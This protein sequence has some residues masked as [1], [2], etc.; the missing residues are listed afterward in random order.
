MYYWRIT[1]YDPSLRDFQGKFLGNEWTS[2]SDI[3]NFYGDKQLILKDYLTVENAYIN[4]VIRFM[5]CSKISS[6][7]IVE[8]EKFD[9]KTIYEDNYSRK[10]IIS[11]ND[12]R[13][14][15]F[16]DQQQIKN[17]CKLILR[18]HLWAKLSYDSKMYV[19][20]GYDYYMYIGSLLP[21]EEAIK[22]I[23]SQG[24]FVE[25]FKSPYIN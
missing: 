20:F 8:L 4:A 5:N 1:K 23:I 25:K 3:G 13:V 7:R 11:F 17:M 10:A 21:C 9:E 15:S 14:G 12:I 24:L 22:N 19:H 2:Y 16:I 18:E 6:L